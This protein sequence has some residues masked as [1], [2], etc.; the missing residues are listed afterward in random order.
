LLFTAGNDSA[1]HISLLSA[2]RR[3]FEAAYP[4]LIHGYVVTR[5]SS[6]SGNDLLDDASGLVHSAFGAD[7]PCIYVIRPDAYIAYQSKPPDGA[8]LHRFFREVYGL[9]PSQR[10]HTHGEGN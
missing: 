9:R 5:S 6:L 2:I 4:N 10:W 7:V 3:D 8:A 1:E